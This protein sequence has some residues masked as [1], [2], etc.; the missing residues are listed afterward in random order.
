MKEYL[1]KVDESIWV[2]MQRHQ[3]FIWDYFC[4]DLTGMAGSATVIAIILFTSVM[5]IM[6]GDTWQAMVNMVGYA[7]GCIITCSLK[8]LFARSGPLP[9]DPFH[10]GFAKSIKVHHFPAFPS[11]HTA[12]AVFLYLSLAI[13]GGVAAP[14]CATFFISSALILALLIGVGKM[15]L[16]AHWLTD[17]IAGYALGLLFV[18]VWYTFSFTI[19]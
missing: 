16:G 10:T 5:L 8:E 1:K 3:H 19:K 4:R 11:G 18:Y 17:V 13:L 7:F 2:W 15:Y 12:M 9:Y 14:V 6:L